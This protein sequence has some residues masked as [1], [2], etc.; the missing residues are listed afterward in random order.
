MMINALSWADPENANWTFQ[1][2]MYKYNRRKLPLCGK[3]TELT[4]EYI[5]ILYPL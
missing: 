3:Q 2:S 5:K 1:L 4:W